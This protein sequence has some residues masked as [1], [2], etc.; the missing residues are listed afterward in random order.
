MSKRRRRSGDCVVV[1]VCRRNGIRPA[2]EPTEPGARSSPQRPEVFLTTVCSAIWDCSERV[3]IVQYI[4]HKGPLCSIHRTFSALW[5]WKATYPNS[6]M[7]A[8]LLLHP[9][10]D[11]S[12]Q[13][14]SNQNILNRG[15]HP[16]RLEETSKIRCQRQS[17]RELLLSSPQPAEQASEGLDLAPWYWHP[18]PEE[19]HLQGCAHMAPLLQAIGT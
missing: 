10:S 6:R 2:R 7:S 18:C 11:R 13:R 5:A 12:L 4:R 9:L 17:L 19:T 14:H 3:S 8:F 15:F 16:S 1:A